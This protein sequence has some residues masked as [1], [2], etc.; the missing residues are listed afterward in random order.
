MIVLAACGFVT[1]LAWQYAASQSTSRLAMLAGARPAIEAVNYATLQ[2]AIDALPETGGVVRLPAGTFEI[3]RPLRITREDVLITG[4]GTATHIKNNNTNGEPAI[5]IESPELK[6]NPRATLWRIELQNLRI[7]GNEKSGHGIWARRINEIYL[8]GVTVSYHGG[9]GVFLDFCT[10]DPRVCDCLFSY[11][12]ATGL[13]VEGCHDILVVGNHFEE[14]KDAVHC[15][16][17]FNLCMTGNNVDDHLRHGVVI[18]NT[19]GSVV[20]G[21]MIEQCQGKAMVLDRDCYGITLASNVLAHNHEGGID[22]RDAHGCAVSANTFTRILRDALRIGPASG[23]ITVTGNNFAGSYQGD[24]KFKLPENN[25]QA[26]GIVL[27]GT[28][29]IAISGNSFS[30]LTTKAVTLEGEAS[31]RVLFSGNVLTE[32]SSDHDKL[33]KHGANVE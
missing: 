32:V 27:A 25:R 22:L 19:Y 9:D 28:S 10:E 33:P 7:T 2:E 15:H 3:D 1:V 11:N 30:S 5:L 31:K 29:D 14:N 13:H 16:D 23:R 4:S 21:N 20:S 24:G 6:N 26:A 8:H 18:E 17:G 12:K